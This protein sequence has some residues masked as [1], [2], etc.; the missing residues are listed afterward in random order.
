[1]KY[2]YKWI[3]PFDNQITHKRYWKHQR[4]IVVNKPTNNNFLGWELPKDEY[5]VSLDANGAI[6]YYYTFEDGKWITYQAD[7]NGENITYNTFEFT[8]A[9]DD[10]DKGAVSIS[11]NT[12]NDYSSTTDTITHKTIEDVEITLNATPKTGYE[13]VKWQRNEEDLTDTNTTIVVK[14]NDDVA[15]TAVFASE[16]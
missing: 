8:A 2:M 1:M 5:L 12:P 11:V 6:E 4:Y 13:F 16:S 14:E 9:A 15:Y 3:K 10:T 7:S